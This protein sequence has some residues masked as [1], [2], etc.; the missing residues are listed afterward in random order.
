FRPDDAVLVRGLGE[1]RLLTVVIHT[2][3]VHELCPEGLRNLVNSHWFE[4]PSWVAWWAMPVGHGLATGAP[5]PSSVSHG[6]DR[7]SCPWSFAVR[8]S[9]ERRP[10]GSRLLTWS[11][12]PIS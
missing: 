10:P 5:C 7:S 12:G 8:R 4:F 1:D 2:E 11:A 6:V 9:P 3:Y